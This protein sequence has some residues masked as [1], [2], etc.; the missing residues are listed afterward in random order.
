MII[1]SFWLG[2]RDWA[3][4][5]GGLVDCRIARMRDQL[6]R[7]GGEGGDGCRLQVVGCGFGWVGSGESGGGRD[8]F[9]FG[10]LGGCGMGGGRFG[11]WGVVGFMKTTTGILDVV[12]ND[13]RWGDVVQNDAVGECGRRGRRRLRW[14]RWRHA[15]VGLGR[16]A[17]EV[18]EGCCHGGDPPWE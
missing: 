1:C 14:W 11:G 9:D 13:A 5:D 15:L 12:Q 8:G 3:E 2:R 10:G 4:R 16:F 7:D 6:G 17:I 18:F